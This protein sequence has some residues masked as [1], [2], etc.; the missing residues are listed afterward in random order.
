MYTGFELLTEAN[1]SVFDQLLLKEV[2]HIYF[3]GGTISPYRQDELITCENFIG[4]KCLSMENDLQFIWEFYEN[5]DSNFT[6]KCYV[7]LATAPH[8]TGAQSAFGSSGFAKIVLEYF[9]IERIELYKYFRER[10]PGDP[11]YTGNTNNTEI[12]KYHETALMIFCKDKKVLIYPAE[13]M[14]SVSVLTDFTSI[15]KLLSIPDCF[16]IWKVFK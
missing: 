13:P 5:K 1:Y 14:S 7:K 16:K 10:N 8:T 2:N 12:N 15:L 11:E 6:S 4:F 3:T 9:K